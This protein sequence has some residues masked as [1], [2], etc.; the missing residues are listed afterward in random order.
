MSRA[1]RAVKQQ[2]PSPSP[3]RPHPGLEIRE[4][5]K[6]RSVYT[7]SGHKAGETLFEHRGERRT[8][9]E[10]RGLP[11]DHI[12][13]IG[14]NLVVLASGEIDDFINHSCDPNC[15]VEFLPDGRVAS[16]AVRAIAPGEELTFDYTTTTSREGLAA[17][18]GWRFPCRCG[19]PSCRGVVSCAEELPAQRL[20]EY[21]Q[22][23]MLAP[24]LLAR[25][26]TL[27]AAAAP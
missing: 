6:G 23:R 16:V 27:L 19:A 17:F 15:R 20:R 18:P 9:A 14:D 12:M 26:R 7:R 11:Q 2:P 21:A 8:F 3:L 13:E 24:H 5:Q 25:L 10:A 4:N 22:K 1:V